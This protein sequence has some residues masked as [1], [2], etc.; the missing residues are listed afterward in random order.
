MSHLRSEL[1]TDEWTRIV[2]GNDLDLD[3]PL[4]SSIGPG[5]TDVD[6]C[7]ARGISKSRPWWRQS[8][9]SIISPAV[10]MAIAVDAGVFV[11]NGFSSLSSNVAIL[12]LARGMDRATIRLL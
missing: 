6:M 9:G 7:D 2:V 4:T 11:G 10:D 5:C 8:A 12:R 3:V 1:V